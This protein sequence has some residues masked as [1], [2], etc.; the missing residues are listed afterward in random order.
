MAK[1]ATRLITYPDGSHELVHK[2]LCTSPIHYRD[3]LVDVTM[4]YSSDPACRFYDGGIPL[5]SVQAILI[6]YGF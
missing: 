1:Q 2:W 5:A 4:R 6:R 3:I